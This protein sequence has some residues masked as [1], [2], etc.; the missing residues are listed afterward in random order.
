MQSL[1]ILMLIFCG[2]GIGG[3]G[4]LFIQSLLAICKKSELEDEVERL[5]TLV[6]IAFPPVELKKEIG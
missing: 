1:E 4:M 5:R 6:D 3:F 2:I